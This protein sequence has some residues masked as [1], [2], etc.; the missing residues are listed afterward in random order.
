MLFCS[1][2]IFY[3][4]TAKALAALLVDITWDSIQGF[5]C[6]SRIYW[7][8]WTMYRTVTSKVFCCHVVVPFSE[9]LH[10]SFSHFVHS[11]GSVH[12][13]ILKCLSRCFFIKAENTL[14]VL[15]AVLKNWFLFLQ[16][17]LNLLQ[18]NFH[19]LY[20]I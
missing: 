2:V 8:L 10:L 5:Y 18:D 7:L 11:F 3:P 14:E 1:L 4:A 17:L 20:F 13:K 15:W 9:A 6:L 19:S 16:F 12:L